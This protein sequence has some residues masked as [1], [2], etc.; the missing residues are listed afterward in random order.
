MVFSSVI[1]LFYFLPL[2]LFVYYFARYR[3]FVF[4]VASLLFYSWG[5]IEYLYL[6]IASCVV[7][8][9]FGLMIEK[10]R[11]FSAKSI[12]GSRRFC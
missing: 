3:N 9:A 8:Y 11:P 6:L 12:T 2:T 10:K 1:F 7:N 5:E 4:L